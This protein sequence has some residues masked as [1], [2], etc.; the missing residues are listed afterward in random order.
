MANHVFKSSFGQCECRW[1]GRRRHAPECAATDEVR[2]AI[3]EYAKNNGRN[4][5]AALRLCWESGKA[6]GA[7][8]MARNII[9]PS[10]LD[11]LSVA[12]LERHERRAKS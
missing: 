2:D 10:G 3:V 7:L 9:G 8:Q 12:L 11:K 6:T 4:W 5:K 1:C